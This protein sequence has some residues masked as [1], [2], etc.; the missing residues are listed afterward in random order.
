M[1]YLLRRDGGNATWRVLKVDRTEPTSPVAVD[2]RDCY[3][4]GERNDLLRRLHHGN[5]AT[6]GLKFVTKCYGITGFVKFLA[7]Y[8][9]VLIGKICGYAV[10]AVD[11]SEISTVPGPNVVPNV[12]KSNDEKR[13]FYLLIY[14]QLFCSV[15]LRDNFFFSYSYNIIHSLQ[16]NI[17]DKNISWPSSKRN[18]SW[19][20]QYGTTFVWNEFLTRGILEHLKDP[21]WTDKISVSGKEFW[22]T[23]IARRSRH[24]V[25]PRFLKRGVNENG[26]VAN[27]V[28]T[29]QIVFEETQD[30]MPSNITSVVQHRGSIPLLW[31][32]EAKFPIKPDITIKPDMDYKATQLHF[33]DLLMRY[34]NP[35]IILNL[36]KVIEKKPHES[37]LRVEFVK[38]IDHI[39]KGL[40]KDNQFKFVHLDMKNHARSCDVLPCLVMVGSASLAHTDFLHCQLTATSHPDDTQSQHNDVRST[41]S[42]IHT[43]GP[44]FG[45]VE[46]LPDYNCIDCL[47]R[48]NVAQF[49]YGLVALGRQVATLVH[50]QGMEIGIDDPLSCTLIAFYEKMGDS[51]ALQC[52]GSAAQ[53]MVFWRLGGQWSAICQWNELTRNVQ[54]FV[55]NACMDS[56]KQNALNVFLGHSQPE[57]GRPPV[58][59]L[60]SATVPQRQG[61]EINEEQRAR[62]T[63]YFSLIRWNEMKIAEK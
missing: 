41:T 23:V 63:E 56:A 59:R 44:K 45:T 47:D 39:N 49:A 30:E 16:K 32:Q 12:A 31:S 55:S 37:L 48:T 54:R 1:L 22:L 4:D 29:E 33:D 24:F 62:Y 46:V 19:K 28:E 7:P 25:G 50:N 52:T 60:G 26:M 9:M 3:S 8:Y 58:W 14:M 21:I 20:S 17:V 15:N 10:Y 5:A 2:D 61:S 43:T 35:I 53:N 27:D 42:T 57:Q 51:L 36:I 6:G 11:K 13:S 18:T 34:G 38:T 40:S